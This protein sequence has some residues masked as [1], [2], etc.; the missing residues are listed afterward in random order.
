M[1]EGIAKPALAEVC[2]LYGVPYLPLSFNRELEIER[3]KTEVAT[4]AA[5]LHARI[6]HLA[7]GGREGFRRAKAREAARRRAIGAAVKALHRH[8]RRRRFAVA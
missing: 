6:A 7:A 2:R 5:L 1:P 8:V 3:V 4:F